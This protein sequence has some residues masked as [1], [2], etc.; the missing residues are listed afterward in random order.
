VS[1]PAQSE[2]HTRALINDLA[3]VM[4]EN[5]ELL[6]KLHDGLPDA[7]YALPML[8]N[9]AEFQANQ[10]VDRLA[11]FGFA[12]FSVIFRDVIS[13]AHIITEQRTAS[14]PFKLYLESS[15]ELDSSVERLF[16]FQHAQTAFLNEKSAMEAKRLLVA[17]VDDSYRISI[18]NSRR[19]SALTLLRDKAMHL[20]APRHIQRLLNSLPK[21]Q[22]VNDATER[23]MVTLTL[24]TTL[25]DLSPLRKGLPVAWAGLLKELD[26]SENE[27]LSFLAFTTGLRNNSFRWYKA[28]HLF[29]QLSSFCQFYKRH[30]LARPQ[31]DTLLALM[32]SDI[33]DAKSAGVVIPFLRIGDWYRYWWFAY[34]VLVPSLVF[35]S[36][37]QRKYSDLWSRTFGSD[38]ALVA[39]YIAS[40]LPTNPDVVVITRRAKKGI[41]DID[42]ALLN[43]KSNELLL[44]ELKT[45]FDRFRTDFQSTNFTVQRVN[46][47]KA[48]VQLQTAATAIADGRWPLR[49]IFPNETFVSPPR[50][51][52][53]IL[54]WRDHP[55][56]T[57]DT[58]A[59]IPVVDFSSFIYLVKECSFH[60]SDLVETIEHLAKVYMTSVFTE[61]FFPL[62]DEKIK[63]QREG[64][65]GGLPPLE[66]MR[67][68][69]ISERALRECSSLRH[70]PD[71]WKAQVENKDPRPLNF[72]ADL[73]FKAHDALR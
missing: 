1:Q 22:F 70:L 6:P 53:L 60:L 34:H 45:V 51:L 29:S 5:D 65:I 55:N 36:A 31:F 43:T 21:P 57:L 23:K 47:E 28:D 8:F 59:Y 13:A 73:P 56:P 66:F 24:E 64:E 52:K 50:V 39:D 3:R 62:G 19:R 7:G 20:A 68:L 37:L 49:E 12:D 27:L 40:Q 41:G 72:I 61:D 26:V 32:S 2:A 44:C 33:A 67:N 69:A 9:C 18:A 11:P 15:P 10:A 14:E 63:F 46:F 16:L 71:D 35:V 4:A 54:L 38:M 25:E 17:K 58:G 30:P 42:L 48:I